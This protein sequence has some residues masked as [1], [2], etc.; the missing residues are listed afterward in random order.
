MSQQ[1]A[2]T[3]A[4]RRR[5]DAYF[6][7]TMSRQ[8]RRLAEMRGVLHY[9]QNRTGPATGWALEAPQMIAITDR[10]CLDI[11]AV[12]IAEGFKP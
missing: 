1:K 6:P 7:D 12:L 9:W 10:A 3:W 5:Q 2:R 8:A 11:A 4:A